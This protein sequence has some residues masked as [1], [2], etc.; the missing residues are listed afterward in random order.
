MRAAASNMPASSSSG[1]SN[2]RLSASLFNQTYK[3]IS[4]GV[5]TEDSNRSCWP[6][7][8]R[9]MLTWTFFFSQ[10]PILSHP[11]TFTFLPESSYR[12]MDNMEACRECF[13][14]RK[15]FLHRVIICVTTVRP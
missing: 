6:L 14:I 1:V 7:R 11:K 4:N 3:L 12:S 2:L 10:W 13:G 5:T 15:R 8:I 9:H